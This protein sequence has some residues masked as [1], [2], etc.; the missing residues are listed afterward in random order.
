[1]LLDYA[2]LQAELKARL[3]GKR[4]HLK[5]GAITPRDFEVY[6]SGK[7]LIV[8]VTFNGDAP[9]LLLNTHG[10]IYFTGVPVFDPK[11]HILSIKDFN[12]TRQVDNILV[13]AATW[14]LQDSMRSQMQARM[15][16]DLTPY[17]EKEKADSQNFLNKPLGKGFNMS[18]NLD[19]LNISDL[20]L[21]A[22]GIVVGLVAQGKLAIAATQIIPG[23]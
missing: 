7:N 18:G 16:W 4:I 13:H 6:T 15:N 3:A 12:Y 2:N 1:V 5:Q 23:D 20:Q 14:V 8:G 19:D 10:T 11:T 22:D 21:Q 9:G 17:V